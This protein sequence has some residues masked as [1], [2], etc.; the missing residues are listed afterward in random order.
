MLHSRRLM[1]AEPL[2]ILLIGDDRR[3]AQAVT[4][5][6]C[7]ADAATTVSLAPTLETGLAKLDEFRHHAIL[8]E[9]PTAN[10]ASL[11]HVTLLASKAARVPIIVSGPTNEIYFAAEVIHAGAQDYLEKESFDART[12]PRTLRCAIERHLELVALIDEKDNYYSVFDH[13]VEGIF[14]T[15]PNGHYLLANVALAN[16]Y[17]YNTPTEL[18]AR[19]TD[20]AQ[21][22]YV[23]AGRREE[24]VQLMQAND[25]I[26][27]FE[28]KIYRK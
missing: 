18:M 2:K 3:F 25:T 7:A 27:D 6:L 28:S 16:I 19:I 14:R 23:E 9:L 17:G 24:F 21:G 22:L 15:T 5:A 26:T 8:F 11:F 12:F 4:D 13:L 1:E 20:I 10:T